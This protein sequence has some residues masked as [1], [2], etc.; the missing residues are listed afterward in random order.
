MM[1]AGFL[2]AASLLAAQAPEGSPDATEIMHRVAEN[3]QRAH[4]ARA[5]WVFNQDVFVRQQR[6]GGKLAR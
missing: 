2:F 4:A 1:S 6:T 3:Q 5:A